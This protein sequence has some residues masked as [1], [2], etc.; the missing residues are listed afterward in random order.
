MP[1]IANTD[2]ERAAMLAAVGKSLDARNW[3]SRRELVRLVFDQAP[4]TVM[5]MSLVTR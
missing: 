4:P 3:K 2:A 5:L 1:F